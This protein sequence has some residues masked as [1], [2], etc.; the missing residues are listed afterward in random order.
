MSLETKKPIIDAL[1]DAD[2]FLL[3]RYYGY[4]EGPGNNLEDIIRKVA[5]ARHCCVICLEYLS[6]NNP[7]F[8]KDFFDMHNRVIEYIEEEVAR[9][10]FY[11]RDVSSMKS[12]RDKL[13]HSVRPF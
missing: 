3:D 1:K 12:L 10:T 2:Y 9:E 6:T 13:Y 4:S 11:E 7:P 5:H 8:T